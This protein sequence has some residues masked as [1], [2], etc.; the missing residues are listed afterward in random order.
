[1]TYD[2]CECGHQRLTHTLAGDHCYGIVGPA[3]TVAAHGT[4]LRTGERCTCYSFA[5]LTDEATRT[6]MANTEM[7]MR[8]EQR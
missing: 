5:T 6:A 7:Q 1:M 3:R 4:T 2:I 8:E